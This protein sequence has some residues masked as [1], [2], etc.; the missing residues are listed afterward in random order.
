[1]VL[2][3]NTFEYNLFLALTIII[4]LVKF[5][6]SLYLGKRKK[7]KKKERGE[8]KF[9]FLFGIFFLFVCLFLSR[10]FYMIFDFGLTEFDPNLYYLTPNIYVYKTAELIS[11][12]GY[13][14]AVYIIDKELIDFKLKGSLAYIIIIISV[15]YL[16]YPVSNQADFE[17]ISLLGLIGNFM[18]I[19]I[20]IIFVYVGI[21]TPSIRRYTFI[22]AAG[23]LI[24]GIGANLVT[25]TL[26][27]S[28]ELILGPVIR[29]ILYLGFLILKTAGLLMM[30]YG[31]VKFSQ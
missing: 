27:S 2:E 7:E 30:A 8:I 9:D 13:I 10:I 19:I 4:V 6:I 18:I 23:V 28:L 20:I 11:F 26:V 21:Q 14:V 17:V 25:E 24:Y 3:S 5:S 1:M 29:I 16:L 12:L 31:V 15:V 22:M